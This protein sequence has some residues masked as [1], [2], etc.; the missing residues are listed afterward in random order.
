LHVADTSGALRATRVVSAT[1]IN[2][3]DTIRLLGTRR[4]RSGQPVLD[5]VTTLFL[6]AGVAPTPAIVKTVTAANASAGR[7]DAALVQVD[8]AMI[9]DTLTVSGGFLL[10]TN[11]GSGAL[12]VLLEQAAGFIGPA[13]AP[14][15]PGARIQATGVLV[16]TGTGAWQL[17]PRSQFDVVLE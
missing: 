9:V 5:S 2:P 3:G 4:T 12:G 10:T 11:D 1:F 7:L 13:L 15:T 6:A 14:Y 16:P 17:K 8:S